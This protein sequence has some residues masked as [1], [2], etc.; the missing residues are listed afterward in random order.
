MKNT[1]KMMVTIAT[2]TSIAGGMTALAAGEKDSATTKGKVNFTTGGLE[3]GILPPTHPEEKPSFP[4]KPG[5]PGEPGG[6]GEGGPLSLDFAPGFNFDI[7][8]VSTKDEEYSAKLITDTNTDAEVANFAQVSDRR[9]TST[10]WELS[11]TQ[12]DQFKTEDGS[13]L[14]GAEL[15][16]KNST[17]FSM[18]PEMTAA[19]VTKEQDL[20]ITPEATSVLMEA[21]DGKGM[22]SHTIRFGSM[23][24]GSAADAVTL[25][26][27][28]T[29]IQYAD[30][31]Y[32]TILNWNINAKP[33]NNEGEPEQEV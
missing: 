23:E 16:L 10:G 21:N 32:T 5:E 18:M 25:K 8:E 19:E 1:M 22:G 13:E 12:E 26:V 9:G 20:K 15:H 29:A 31:E 27:P 7:H 30:K 2:L 24:D 11:L 33:D 4:I 14:N 3:G 28:G 6:N 17:Y